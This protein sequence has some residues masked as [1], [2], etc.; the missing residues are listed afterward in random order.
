[1]VS[2][3]ISVWPGCANSLPPCSFGDPCGVAIGVAS[4]CVII[5]GGAQCCLLFSS[6]G[7]LF[8]PNSLSEIN[9]VY[10]CY[11]LSCYI[12]CKDRNAKAMC[13][14]YNNR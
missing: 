1:M 13:H 14:L 6:F 9:K 5:G 11:Q 12:D 10:I 3:L 7:S 2:V 8:R 4:V